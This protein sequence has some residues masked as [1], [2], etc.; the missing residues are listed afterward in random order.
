M[1]TF[2]D[3]DIFWQSFDLI[4]K[5]FK[6]T[7]KFFRLLHFRSQNSLL[8]TQVS[9]VVKS[10][11]EL[12]ASCGLFTLFIDFVLFRNMFSTTTLLKLSQKNVAEPF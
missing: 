6:G 9:N 8:K 3:F 12:F 11:S 7:A 5:E 10:A 4:G 2:F 1:Q